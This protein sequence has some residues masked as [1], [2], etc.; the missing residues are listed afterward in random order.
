MLPKKDDPGE[1]CWIVNGVADQVATHT[2]FKEVAQI[3]LCP[4]L[5]VNC[6]VC[7]MLISMPENDTV[8][9]MQQVQIGSTVG[10]KSKRTGTLSDH[11]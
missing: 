9:H 7:E 2:D 5:V 11:A 10:R 6:I 4:S 1:A 8:L 3:S